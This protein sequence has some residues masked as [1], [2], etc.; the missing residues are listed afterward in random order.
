MRNYTP[1]PLNVIGRE[2]VDLMRKQTPKGKPFN[3]PG[4]KWWQVTDGEIEILLYCRDKDSPYLYETAGEVM[5]YILS[6]ISALRGPEAKRLK[7]ELKD[8]MT[9]GGP[10]KAEQRL[11]EEFHHG[12]CTV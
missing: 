6:H 2:V 4:G 3:G 5:P 1:R 10:S 7:A 11:I 9:Y 12:Q 8:H